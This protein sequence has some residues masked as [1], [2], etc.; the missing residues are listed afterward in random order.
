MQ[1]V[2]KSTPIK[3]KLHQLQKCL[4]HSA[5]HSSWYYWSVPLNVAQHSSWHTG[6]VTWAEFLAWTRWLHFSFQCIYPVIH[7][8]QCIHQPHSC[9]EEA[10]SPRRPKSVFV[11]WIWF[12]FYCKVGHLD[13]IRKLNVEGWCLHQIFSYS[14]ENDVFIAWN[15]CFIANF[16]LHNCYSSLDQLLDTCSCSKG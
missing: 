6:P 8:N 16:T 7:K 13:R 5:P 11:P 9:F 12:L 10:N 3:Y 14:E 1:S 4:G 2:L 15:S